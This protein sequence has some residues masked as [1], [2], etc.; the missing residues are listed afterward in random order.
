MVHRKSVWF[1][2]E[3]WTLLGE[4]GKSGMGWQSVHF[5]EDYGDTLDNALHRCAN[6][7]RKNNMGLERMMILCKCE[8][9]EYRRNVG[10]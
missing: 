1:E 9:V 2:F 3:S 5:D 10:M 8:G 4:K 6:I 7:V